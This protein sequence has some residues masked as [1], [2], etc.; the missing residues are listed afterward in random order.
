MRTPL[1]VASIA[2]FF[3]AVLP[4][5]GSAQQSANAAFEVS[6]VKASPPDAS[7]GS[8]RRFDAGIVSL[9]SMTLKE[10]IEW[11]FDLRPYQVLGGPD[12]ASKQR[13][14]IVGKDSAPNAGTANRNDREYWIAVSAADSVKM[15]DLL[16]DRFSLQYHD[17]TRVVPGFVL[18]TTKG[19][20]FVA[21]PCLAKSYLQH[22]W[23]DGAIHM[24]SL[25]G[26]LKADL[27]VPVEDKTGLTDC[28]HLEAK[29]T[30]DPSETSL[31]QIPTALHDLG[32]QLQRTKINTNVLVIDHA[33]LL[34]PD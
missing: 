11:S 29:W 24:S 14:D 20:K 1:L 28:Y 10:A 3:L 34:K 27:G 8:F 33:E 26:L 9:R 21:K 32:L 4:S 25:A 17:E 15:R 13:F 23:V 19:S 31:P 5:L 7:Q 30:T 22:G 16:K 2:S 18:L 6:S 12:W